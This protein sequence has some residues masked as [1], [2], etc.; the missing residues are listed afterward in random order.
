M[1]PKMIQAVSGIIKV[2]LYE[3][4]SINVVAGWVPIPMCT[5]MGTNTYLQRRLVLCVKPI[6]IF[7]VPILRFPSAFPTVNFFQCI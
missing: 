4:D 5:K 2:K 3:T 6:S 7:F 1:L